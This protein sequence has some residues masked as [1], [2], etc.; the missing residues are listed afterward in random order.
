MQGSR[1]QHTTDLLLS[2]SCLSLK[3]L[4]W[5]Q[6][7]WIWLQAQPLVHPCNNSVTELGMTELPLPL[8]CLSIKGGQIPSLFPNAFLEVTM[9]A[10]ITACV[11]VGGRAWVAYLTQSWEGSIAYKTRAEGKHHLRNQGLVLKGP[12]CYPIRAKGLLWLLQCGI[13]SVSSWKDK[14]SSI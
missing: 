8:L 10:Q 3:V 1:S 14:S 12:A 11:P 13:P 5:L 4:P 2:S 9:S 7:D 6:S